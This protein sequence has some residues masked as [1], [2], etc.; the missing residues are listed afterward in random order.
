MERILVPVEDC[1]RLFKKADNG[2][3]P[4]QDL[5]GVVLGTVPKRVRGRW[6]GDSPQEGIGKGIGDSPQGSVSRLGDRC[7]GHTGDSPQRGHPREEIILIFREGRCFGIIGSMKT[8]VDKVKRAI[9][10]GTHRGNQLDD[11]CGWHNYPVRGGEKR[12]GNAG[13]Q[14]LGNGGERRLGNSE[15]RYSRKC[16]VRNR[17][18]G[19]SA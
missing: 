16:I 11:W 4:P 17:L 15:W 3:S 10:V 8:T 2:D 18:C 6:P 7:D 5:D 12:L 14:R 1:P 9:L 13:D 19:N